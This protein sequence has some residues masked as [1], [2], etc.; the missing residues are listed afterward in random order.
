[1]EVNEKWG[2]VSSDLGPAKL[3][4]FWSGVS[5]VSCQLG[6]QEDR[7]LQ[8]LVPC[9]FDC[10]AKP[11]CVGFRCKLERFAAFAARLFGDKGALQGDVWG[12][13]VWELRVWFFRVWGCSIAAVGLVTYDVFEAI[14][15]NCVVIEFVQK[16]FFVWVPF[17]GM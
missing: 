11:K 10:W 5:E 4:L 3:N 16:F 9:F 17:W 14:G 2:Q 12:C 8:E 1:V 7:P 13:H 15:P 6:E